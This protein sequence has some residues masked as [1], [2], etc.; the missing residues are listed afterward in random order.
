MQPLA[1]VVENDAALAA[2]RAYWTRLIKRLHVGPPYPFAPV[3]RRRLEAQVFG[4]RAR[5]E[6]HHIGL[7]G[8]DSRFVWRPLEAGQDPVSHRQ[9]PSAGR[10]HTCPS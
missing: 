3:P 5:G 7:V 9:F 10:S 1:E 8:P 2:E 6:Q 4:R